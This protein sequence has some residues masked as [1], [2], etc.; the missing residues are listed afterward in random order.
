MPTDALLKILLYDWSMLSSVCRPL[1]GQ[2]KGPRITL[3]QA[4][5]GMIL[6]NQRW[7]PACIFTVKIAAIGSLK[8]V[9]ERNFKN[10]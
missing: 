3:L 5:S 9:I 6:Q 10:Y 7:L 4:A 1:I 8:R 2:G